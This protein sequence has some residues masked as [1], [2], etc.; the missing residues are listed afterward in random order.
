M[1]SFFRV[2]YATAFSSLR[3]YR[4][5]M[6]LSKS[7]YVA[8]PAKQLRLFLLSS[9]RKH[10]SFTPARANAA[11]TREYSQKPLQQIDLTPRPST[12]QKKWNQL[13]APQKVVRTATTGGNLLIILAGMAMTVRYSTIPTGSLSMQRPKIS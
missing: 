9:R 2:L 12:S 3:P 6:T 1:K 4:F 8:I 11:F 5:T 7:V 10:T 13:S